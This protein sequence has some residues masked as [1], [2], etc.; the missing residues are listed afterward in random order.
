MK[1]TRQRGGTLLE[2]LVAILIFSAGVIGMMGLQAT[3]I[4]TSSDAQHRTEAMF[5]ANNV[6]ARM[7]MSDPATRAADFKSSAT[8]GADYIQWR[9]EVI[10]LLP[11]VTTTIAP[12]IAFDGTNPEQVTVTVRWQLPGASVH[13]YVTTAEIS[14]D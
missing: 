11:G 14:L 5:A 3:A 9:D 6:I 8:L 1:M 4:R 10:G 7:W 2:S 12:T 13:Q